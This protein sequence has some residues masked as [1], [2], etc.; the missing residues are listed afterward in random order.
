MNIHF[1]LIF[2]A[3]VY[4]TNAIHGF[5]TD[6]IDYAGLLAMP[7]SWPGYAVYV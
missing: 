7:I 1:I 3:I 6:V 5:A 4:G 2:D